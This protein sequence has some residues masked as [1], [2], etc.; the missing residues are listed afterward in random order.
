MAQRHA[1][2]FRHSLA[3]AASSMLPQL[4]LGGETPRNDEELPLG[5]KTPGTKRRPSP[6][7]ERG[8]IDAVPASLGGRDTKEQRRASPLGQKHRDKRRPSPAGKH[9]NID[10]APDSLGGQN[11]KE[12]IMDT[13]RTM[14]AKR[15]RPIYKRAV[16]TTNNSFSWGMKPQGQQQRQRPTF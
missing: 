8:I 6:A 11:P 4:P 9:G 7:G 14:D 12:H 13:S 1:T 16:E 2:A 3:S 5:D 15:Q 10:A